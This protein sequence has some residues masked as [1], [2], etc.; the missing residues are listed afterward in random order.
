MHKLTLTILK[1]PFYL[2]ITFFVDQLIAPWGCYF[3]PTLNTK[4]WRFAGFLSSLNLDLKTS[5]THWGNNSQETRNSHFFQSFC[6]LFYLISIIWSTSLKPSLLKLSCQVWCKNN[7]E[8]CALTVT[9]FYL[10]MTQIQNGKV[11]FG[12]IKAVFWYN[13]IWSHEVYL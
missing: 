3:L 12:V 1:I 8:P 13:D 9:C 10:E 4:L 7:K 6:L 5:M 2:F 11:V